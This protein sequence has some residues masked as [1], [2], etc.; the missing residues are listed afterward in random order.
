MVL[1]QKNW[2]YDGVPRG[3]TKVIMA[4]GSMI[5]Q[6][7]IESTHVKGLSLEAYCPLAQ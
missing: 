7:C 3:R 1:L 2:G 4:K 6:I 5:Y